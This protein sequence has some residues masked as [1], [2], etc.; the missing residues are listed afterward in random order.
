MTEQCKSR[1]R[2][3]GKAAKLRYG[4]PREVVD[5]LLDDVQPNL[6]RCTLLTFR[7]FIT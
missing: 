1:N 5:S 3:G 2:A 4:L 7:S 6:D